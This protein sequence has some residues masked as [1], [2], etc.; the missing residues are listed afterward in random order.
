MKRFVMLYGLLTAKGDE[1]RCLDECKANGADGVRFGIN[2]L[3]NDNDR[4]NGLRPF[5]AA[6]TAI[7]PRE[8]HLVEI[9]DLTRRNP[10]FLV[11][12]RVVA[13]KLKDRGMT[14]WVFFDDR[15]SW[16]PE[17]WKEFN[18][19]W[20]CNLITY[21]GVLA[22]DWT[23][24][25]SGGMQDERL[26][27]YR[28]RLMADVLA[29]FRE[30]GHAEVWGEVS[31]EYGEEPGPAYG[32]EQEVGWYGEQAGFL[33][34]A[35]FDVIVGSARDPIT[36]KILPFVDVYDR[37]NVNGASLAQAAIAEVEALSAGKPLVLDTD[38]AD[39]A[40]AQASI[41]GGRTVDE[42][43]A[44]EI[45][46]AAKGRVSTHTC[47]LSQLTFADPIIVTDL[48]GHE[49]PQLRAMSEAS[50][51]TPQV[52]PPDK[53]RVT[54][55]QL[56]YNVANQYCPATFSEEFVKGTE[57]TTPCAYHKAPEPPPESCWDKYMAD[58]PIRKWQVGKWIKCILGI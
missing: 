7:E 45:G 14:P 5:L 52:P 18:D 11:R 16:A 46:A 8:G 40:T 55:C 12:L 22:G 4:P 9:P 51:W 37:H 2:Y 35:G 42:A 24:H 28:R 54:L 26:N 57:P 33:R 48:D 39:G 38:G 36:T 49:Y 47:Y 6:G 58:R 41:W 56:T 43:Q 20:Y 3:H 29:V 53:V 32:M 44:R 30:A 15:C 17:T 31:N 1:D 19:L 23:R 34:E 25:G 13:R 50:G 10:A 21:P 27:P